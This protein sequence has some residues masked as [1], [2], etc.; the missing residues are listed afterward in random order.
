MHGSFLVT[1]MTLLCLHAIHLCCLRDLPPALRLPWTCRVC[2]ELREWFRDLVDFPSDRDSN[3]SVGSVYGAY[4]RLRLRGFL[5]RQ[6]HNV[7][8]RSWNLRLGIGLAGAAILRGRI[9]IAG[10]VGPTLGINNL[11]VYEKAYA[12]FDSLLRRFPAQWYSDIAC[13]PCCR[14]T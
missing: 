11:L 8:R 6:V 2:E 4:S 1:T 12:V 7:H 9:G 13:M 14:N 5:R 3:S 10:V